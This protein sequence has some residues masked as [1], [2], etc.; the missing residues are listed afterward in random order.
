MPIEEREMDAMGS[1]L[2][3]TCKFSK[4]ILSERGS[5]FVMCLKSKVDPAFPKYPPLPVLRC[6]GYEAENEP[7]RRQE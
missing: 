7:P 2:C 4:V 6:A 3:A 1:G 5:R